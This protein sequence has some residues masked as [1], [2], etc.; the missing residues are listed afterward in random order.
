MDV[1]NP[2]PFPFAQG[3][4]I[5][6][7]W[8]SGRTEIVT[9]PTGNYQYEAFVGLWRSHNFVIMTEYDEPVE[10]VQDQ[11]NGAD[12]DAVPAGTIDE[13][14]AWVGD[15][16]DRAQEALDAEN[17]GKARSTLIEALQKLVDGDDA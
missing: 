2:K 5:E 14:L 1:A 11:G 16:A 15:D 13:V 3:E 17:E 12:P 9:V 8:E 6:I 7:Q 10:G 4:D